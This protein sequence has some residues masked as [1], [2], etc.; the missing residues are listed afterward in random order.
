MVWHNSDNLT[1][2]FGTEESTFRNIGSYNF[3]GPMHFVEV[4][5]DVSELPAVAS[6]STILNDSFLLPIGAVIEHVEVRVPTTA[7]ASSG[8]GTFNLG[9]I[10][11]DRSSNAD[12]DYLVQ[13]ITVAE[14]NAGG[15][16]IA[17]WAGGGF[18]ASPRVALTTAKLLTWEVNTAVYQTGVTVIRIYWSKNPV[19]VGDRLVWSKA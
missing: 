13:E 5:V 7:F 16:D 12:V 15:T 2:K 17:G 4:L 11:A 3:D 18:A 19:N 8:S 14:W 10:D 6:N 1:V 9:L